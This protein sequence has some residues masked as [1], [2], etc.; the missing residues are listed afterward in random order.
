MRALPHRGA[1]DSVRLTTTNHDRD[2]A[3]L[4]YVYPVV[5]RRARGVSV[6]INLNPNDACNWRCVYCQVPGLVQGAAPRIDLAKLREE[7]AGM[8]AT[9]TSAGWMDAHVPAGARR[10][11]DVAFSGNGEATTSHQLDAAVEVVHAVLAGHG[12]LDEIAVVLIT[13][14]SLVH[15]PHVRAALERLAEHR[16]E[17]W[18]KLDSATEEGRRRLNDVAVPDA[19][20]RENLDQCARTCPTRIQTMA[21]ALDG[22]PPSEEEVAAW[23]ALVGDLVRSGTPIR[24]VLLYGLERASHQPEAPRLSPVSDDWLAALAARITRE[25][26]LDVSV[27]P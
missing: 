25:T 10:L 9:I 19:R 5:S 6:G 11:N 23:T 12:L 18:F 17:V 24:D 3:A 14:G 8:L 4:T 26:G 1:L 20:V 2:A 15:R 16:G 27:S 22:E 13:N 7:L 21:L